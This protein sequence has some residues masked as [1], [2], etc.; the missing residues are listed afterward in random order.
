MII[1]LTPARLDRQLTI[2]RQGDTLILNGE[3]HDFSTLAEGEIL[4]AETLDTIWI[5]SDVTRSN[6]EIVLTLIV[7]HGPHAPPETLFP[8]SLH[9]DEDGPIP[10]PA[11]AL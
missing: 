6:G 4:Y 3:T 5:A 9:I 2:E 11:Y 7:P 1:H 10:I 8:T